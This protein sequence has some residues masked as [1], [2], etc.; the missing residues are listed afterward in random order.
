MRYPKT[1]ETTTVARGIEL[2][3]HFGLF[4][5]SEKLRKN[6]DR[7]RSFEFD[8]CSRIP[9]GLVARLSSMSEYALTYKCCLP[10][11]LKYAYGDPG[12]RKAF[13]VANHELKLDIVSNGG[14]YMIANM[15]YDF[16]DLF[17][18]EDGDHSFSWGFAVR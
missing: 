6:P 8:G 13:D 17:G 4:D 15:F 18:W 5:I 9:D 3:E 12:D 7:Y 1:G 2:C 10:H 11:D 14:A 16:T